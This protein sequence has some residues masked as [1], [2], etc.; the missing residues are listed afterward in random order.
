MDPII[1]TRHVPG[2]D[3]EDFVRAGHEVFRGAANRIVPLDLMVHGAVNALIRSA[4]GTPC[5]RYRIY[6][7]PMVGGAP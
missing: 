6:E 2:L 7:K 5:T 4:G 3:V 1:V